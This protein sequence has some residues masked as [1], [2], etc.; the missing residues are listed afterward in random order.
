MCNTLGGSCSRTEIESKQVDRE[1]AL[2]LCRGPGPPPLSDLD[3]GFHQANMKLKERVCL[4][5]FPA[6]TG[7]QVSP[8]LVSEGF[9]LLLCSLM[10][11]NPSHDG[12]KG[13]FLWLSW[14]CLQLRNNNLL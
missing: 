8:V 5:P 1:P 11:E 4:L 10:P 13:S 9:G 6:R 7:E 14:E 12:E 2:Y 3:W